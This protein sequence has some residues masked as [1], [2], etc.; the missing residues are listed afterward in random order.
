MAWKYNPFTKK[1]DYYESA[2][3]IY[4]KKAGDTMTGDLNM[5]LNFILNLKVG[6]VA[7]L[8]ATGN[9]SRITY[10]TTDKHLY[11]DQG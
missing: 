11:L 1:L 3:D 8:P 10:L 4:V 7:I 9:E 5:S 6:Q 2:A